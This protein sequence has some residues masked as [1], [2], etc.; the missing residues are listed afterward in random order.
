MFQT[1]YHW[2]TLYP[3][4]SLLLT[5]FVDFLQRVSVCACVHVCVWWRLFAAWLIKCDFALWF[6]LFSC[7][8]YSALSSG[9]V[10]VVRAL[11]VFHYYYYYYYFNLFQ[12]LGFVCQ[13]VI[14]RCTS[15]GRP[16]RVRLHSHFCD[17][18]VL[19]T[20]LDSRLNFNANSDF[21]NK[22]CQSRLYM[23]F[24]NHGHFM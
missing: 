7:F 16:Q 17:Q 13:S 9:F 4:H 20:V 3:F 23:V 8:L 22:K 18:P 6:S 5:V 21:I 1:Y 14:Y 24:G 15:C 11:Q 12:Q 10:L 2:Q 19:G